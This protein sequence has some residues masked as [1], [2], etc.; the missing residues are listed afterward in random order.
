MPNLQTIKIENNE[1][2]RVIE[3]NTVQSTN[4]IINKLKSVF[5]DSGENSINIDYGDL[6]CI[7]E[8]SNESY[9]LNL[10]VNM[11]ELQSEWNLNIISNAIENNKIKNI[12]LNFKM[13]SKM[14]PIQISKIME[15]IEI[16]ND[17][18]A[19]IIFGTI[20]DENIEDDVIEV[21][22]VIAI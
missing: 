9:L 19:S 4:E 12:L 6:K 8:D 3:N 11:N 7:F 5:L 10:N 18:D 17:E 16:L 13:N 22:A 21:L 2:I 20:I 1:L 15:M 14:E